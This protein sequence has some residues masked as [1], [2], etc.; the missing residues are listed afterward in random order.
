M[1]CVAEHVTSNSGKR[2][3]AFHSTS[4]NSE[5]LNRWFLVNGKRPMLSL[6]LSSYRNTR[7]SLG[8]LEKA[9]KTLACGSSS[10]SICRSPKLRIHSCF[11][12][13][14]K[15]AS[16]VLCSVVKHAG[17]SR[18]RKKCRGKHETKSRSR[19]SC[20]KNWQLICLR[21]LSAGI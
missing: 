20:G 7:E 2:S 11:Y 17:G 9:V 19:K 3:D 12:L 5:N 4:E 18:A 10:Q 14:N 21:V 13:T 1:H 6:F 16:T 8:D 15:E